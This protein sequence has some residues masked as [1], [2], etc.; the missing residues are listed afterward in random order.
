MENEQAE[1]ITSQFTE[2]FAKILNRHGYGFQYSVLKKADELVTQRKSL[3]YFE[4][5]EFP[6]EVQ[7]FGTKIDFVLQRD[8]RGWHT[9]PMFLLAECKR[10][11]PALSNWCF[12][13][14]PYTHRNAYTDFERVILECVR[15]EET[16][17]LN[18][19]AREMHTTTNAY[20]IGFEMRSNFKGDATGETGQ[21][22]EKAATQISRGLNGFIDAVVK[23]DELLE[24]SNQ[25]DF[26]PVIF[27][28]A[29][30]YVSDV[31]LSTAD[32][33]S[34]NVTLENERIKSVPWLFYQYALSPGLKHSLTPKMKGYSL[35]TLLQ[36]QY[37]RSI[38]IVSW[39]GIE[40]FL[41]WSSQ[42]ETDR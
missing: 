13:R 32:V 9:T 36:W 6:V 23:N 35:A 24:K 14:A 5:C 7:G 37:I 41:K 3:W 12:V 25:V 16:G 18:T 2:S 15:R 8:C 19:F 31:D 21:A 17:S 29:R 4:A 26:L 11:N 42:L 34:G 39:S 20:H 22:I 30:L 1:Q 28:T 27:T 38:P 33:G 40:E 10:T